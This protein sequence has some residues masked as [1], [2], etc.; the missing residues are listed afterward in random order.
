MVTHEPL[1]GFIWF[2]VG[3]V[4]FPV[5]LWLSYKTRERFGSIMW[6]LGGALCSLALIA[7]ALSNSGYTPPWKGWGA[8]VFLIAFATFLTALYA[9]RQKPPEEHNDATDED[10]R[11][12]S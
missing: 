8:A 11:Q 1:A 3:V 2:W 10:S 4:L 12:R 6:L 9:A 7:S 5:C